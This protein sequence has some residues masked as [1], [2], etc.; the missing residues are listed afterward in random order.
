[1]AF[2]H[3]GQKALPGFK[4]RQTLVQQK[5]RQPRVAEEIVRNRLTCFGSWPF[6]TICMQRPPQYETMYMS[7]VD[8]IGDE[9]IGSEPSFPTYDGQRCSKCVGLVCARDSNAAC[10]GVQSKQTSAGFDLICECLN[11]AVYDQ[12][13]LVTSK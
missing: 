3:G 10:P 8:K 12:G 5:D 9:R 13:V 1:M 2:G 11:L 4:T 7:F 6:N